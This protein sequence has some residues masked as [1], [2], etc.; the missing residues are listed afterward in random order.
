LRAGQRIGNVG[1]DSPLDG[2]ASGCHLHYQ[3]H[4]RGGPIYGPDNV[5]PTIW[6]AQH[7]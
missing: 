7:A 2:N 6:L 1:G 4:R 3:A 5:N